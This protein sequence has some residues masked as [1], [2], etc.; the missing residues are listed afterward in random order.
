MRESI[1]KY[2]TIW[3]L[4]LSFSMSWIFFEIASLIESGALLILLGLNIPMMIA[5]LLTLFIKGKLTMPPLKTHFIT[6][7]FYFLL[8]IIFMHSILNTPLNLVTI[9]LA[10][11]VADLLAFNISQTFDKRKCCY[12]LRTMY[13]IKSHAA[14]LLMGIILYLVITIFMYFYGFESAL[15]L[16]I[17][18][19]HILSISVFI[20]F[21]AFFLLGASAVMAFKGFLLPVLTVRFSPLISSVIF[22]SIY[23]L[24]FMPI[25]QYVMEVKWNTLINGFAW[26]V[27]LNII[28]IW[29]Y[30]KCRASLLIIGLV[31]AVLISTF[32]IFDFT[33]NDLRIIFIAGALFASLIVIFDPLMKNQPK[34]LTFLKTHSDIDY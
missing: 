4:G 31:T 28:I 26:L 29:L 6:L 3:F 12:L 15:I 17:G 21:I 23:F 34:A 25:Y 22:T 27:V 30:F 14:T 33:M 20:L 16:S 8:V 9:F 19:L 13:D 18:E 2:A 32:I 5:V 24:W 11:F 10:V 7:G 1:T